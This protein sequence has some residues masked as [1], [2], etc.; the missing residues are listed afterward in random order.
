MD[1]LRAHR[2]AIVVDRMMVPAL[3]KHCPVTG[4]SLCLS[5]GSLHPLGHERERGIR[6]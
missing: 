5:H 6:M 1:E 2:G 3:T 4:Y